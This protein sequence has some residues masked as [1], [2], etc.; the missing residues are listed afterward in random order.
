MPELSPTDPL[1]IDAVQTPAGHRDVR[2]E[3][4]AAIPPRP[5]P[6]S[7]RLLWRALLLGLR[8]PGTAHVLRRLRSR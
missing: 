6:L 2:R 1:P 7:K 5:A 3:L 8:I 4:A